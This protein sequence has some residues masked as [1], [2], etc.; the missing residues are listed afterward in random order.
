M[1]GFRLCTPLLVGMGSQFL[2]HVLRAT[3][4]TILR[5]IPANHS[6]CTQRF[7]K[8]REMTDCQM[9]MFLSSCRDVSGKI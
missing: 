3:S 1:R 4:T 9:M 6:N 5:T 2:A 8:R 7:G